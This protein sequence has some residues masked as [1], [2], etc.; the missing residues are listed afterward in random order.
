MSASSDNSG[1]W[2]LPWQIFFFVAVIMLQMFIAITLYP[3]MTGRSLYSV[4]EEEAAG[5]EQAFGSSV[6]ESS[7]AIGDHI[8]D[9]LFVNSGI[10]KFSYELMAP[11][12]TDLLGA[13]KFKEK[14]FGG[15]ILDTVF[16]YLL[17]MSHRFGYSMIFLLFG[18]IFIATLL[19]HAYIDRHR[20]RYEFG[21]KPI[22]VNAYARSFAL[23]SVPLA[24]IVGTL[25][26]SLSP[27]IIMALVAA[28]LSST[29][30]VIVALPKKS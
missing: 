28:S 22:V 20:R 14:W 19:A 29:A 17:L 30:F 3:Y 13:D 24:L 8:Y 9:T 10:E 11:S 12:E 1:L 27:W 6:Q 23:L 7:G 5:Y 15:S 16:D 25:P 2:P 4:I 21:D 18:M 26:V